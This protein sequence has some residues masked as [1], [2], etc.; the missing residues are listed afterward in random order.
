M[1]RHISLP[2]NYTFEERLGNSGR[3]LSARVR[4]ART[5]GPVALKFWRT[6]VWLGADEARGYRQHRMAALE[7]LLSLRHP[8]LAPVCD[9]GE[10]DGGL[11]AAREFVPGVSLAASLRRYGRMPLHEAVQVARQAAAALDALA[12]AGLRHGGLTGHNIVLGDDHRVWL[13]D[14]RMTA[15]G[16]GLSVA[17]AACRFEQTVASPTDLQALAALVF[18]A[19]TG[20]NP[21]SYVQAARHA[22][23]LP[24]TV[25]R[26]L[27]RALSGG[28][29]SFAT[30]QDFAAA[31]LPAPMPTLWRY[32]WRPAAAAGLFG[33]L[34]TAGSNASPAPRST[35]PSHAVAPVAAA[36]ESAPASRPTPSADPRPALSVDPLSAEDRQALI[37]AIHR[38]GLA[39]LNHPAVAEVFA[40]SEEQRNQIA[41][42]LAEQRT[43][44]AMIVDAA[45]EGAKT[46]AAAP[47]HALREETSTRILLVLNDTQRAL[48]ESLAA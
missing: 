31:L 32:A 21:D 10:V 25:R 7:P 30:T 4:D 13:T 35:E 3:S 18:E 9:L 12:A 16:A 29:R 5:G 11:Y 39:V 40:L 27:D 44:V 23:H 47:M 26:A 2:D 22:Y 6:P 45:A 42:C 34:A 19:L 36:Q 17:G 48:W 1:T 14:A 46:E 37:T 38:Q 8:H 15:E 20:W 24:T 43:R 28:G 41:D 33:A